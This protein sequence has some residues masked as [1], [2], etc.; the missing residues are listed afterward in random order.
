MLIKAWNALN[1]HVFAPGQE[2]T[3]LH[4]ILKDSNTRNT[5]FVNIVFIFLSNNT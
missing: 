2:D 3:L 4:S 5:V 1:I